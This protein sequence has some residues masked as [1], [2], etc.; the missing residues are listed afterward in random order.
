MKDLGV[1]GASEEP[2]LLKA[3]ILTLLS[4]QKVGLRG[5]KTTKAAGCLV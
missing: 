3:K 1:C 5:R 2:S 4:K